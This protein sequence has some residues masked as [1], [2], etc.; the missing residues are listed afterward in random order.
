MNIRLDQIPNYHANDKDVIAT[1]ITHDL[2][3]HMD[4]EN[5]KLKA[6]INENFSD[7][8]I[9]IWKCVGTDNKN[10]WLVICLYS[11]ADAAAFALWANNGVD[12]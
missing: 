4:E 9:K 1:W 5:W 12:I 7:V 8:K 3:N 2:S 11:N 6:L 10:E